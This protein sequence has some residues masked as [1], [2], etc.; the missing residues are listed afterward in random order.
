VEL[1]A[2]VIEEIPHGNLRVPR[3]EFVAVWAEAERLCDER[4]GGPGGGWYAAG[5]V[6]TCRWVAGAIVVFNY[7]HGPQARPAAAPITHR[8]ARAHEE[9]IEAET[10]AAERMAIRYPNGIEGRPGW[11]EAVVATLT[12]VWRG[13]GVP[14][15]V[16]RR[17][18]AG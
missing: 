16:I 6:R 10:L 1:T 4:H 9:V 8:R 14:P 3:S 2:R 7:P 15:M 11:L 18:E 12:W 13:S 5:V 17:A